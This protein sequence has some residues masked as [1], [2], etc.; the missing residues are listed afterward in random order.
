MS[1]KFT[2]LEKNTKVTNEGINNEVHVSNEV[3]INDDDLLFA[4]WALFILILVI[5]IFKIY[6][7]IKRSWQTS[8]VRRVANHSLVPV[9]ATPA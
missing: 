1:A 2:G 3:H 5:V 4:I 9:T 6:N 7:Y 8:V